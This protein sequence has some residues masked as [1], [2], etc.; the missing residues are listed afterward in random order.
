MAESVPSAWRNRIVRYGEEAPD[1]LLANPLN[2]RIHPT[3]QKDTLLALLDEVGWIRPVIVSLKSGFVVDGHLRVSVALLRDEP[4]VP[5][6]YVNLTPEEEVKILALFDAVGAMATVDPAVLDKALATVF[7]TRPALTTALANLHSVAHN[8]PQLD[9]VFPLAALRSA[10]PAPDMDED[11]LPS[12]AP[13]RAALSADPGFIGGGGSGG[14]GAAY[15]GRGPSGGEGFDDGDPWGG[16]AD[17]GPPDSH[18]RMVQLFLSSATHPVFL[19]H[20]ARLRVHFGTD[21]ATD[22]VLRAVAL[23]AGG[24]A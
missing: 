3:Q 20:E 12:A 13:G 4:A 7:T 14:T 21:N 2:A 22:T 18:V 10:A 23:V 15:P 16:A 24:A 6:A 11:A 8:L 5:V 19:D 9:A 1:Q 17:G